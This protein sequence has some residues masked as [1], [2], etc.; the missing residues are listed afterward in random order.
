MRWPL[1]V[2]VDALAWAGWSAA[3]GL[4]HARLSLDRLAHDG[5]VLRL[6]R[7][8]TRRRYQRWLRIRAWKDALPEA[9]SWF[10]GLSKRRLPRG[11]AASLDR[12]AVECR[13]AERT[14]WCIL[15]AIPAFALWNPP[16]LFAV[17]IAFAVLV[18]L[19]CIAVL[20]YNRLRLHGLVR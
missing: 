17:M 15:A 12:F 5:P 9:G 2:V 6:R 14:H 13:R 3:V 19:P 7:W 11:G 20:R 10:G 16:W 8:E 1:A 18:N 4:W